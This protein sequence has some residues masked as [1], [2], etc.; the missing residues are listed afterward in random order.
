M[1]FSVIK[2]LI[3]VSSVTILIVASATAMMAKSDQSSLSP[4]NIGM[5]ESDVLKS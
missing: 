1:L 3:A 4:I 5:A 2:S